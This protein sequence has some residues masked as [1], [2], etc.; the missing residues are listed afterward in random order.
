[1]EHKTQISNY[2]ILAE[3]APLG[4]D[5]PLLPEKEKEKRGAKKHHPWAEVCSCLPAKHPV[6]TLK[7]HHSNSR[8]PPR[9]SS[10]TTSKP[11]TNPTPFPGS[12]HDP[13]FSFTSKRPD[14]TSI[15]RFSLCSAP[16]CNSPKLLSR[17]ENRADYFSS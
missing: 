8:D 1:M 13:N 12:L 16:C 5:S 10:P 11:H 15:S 3:F 7:L 17:A 4:S 9:T 14:F 2:C 6:D